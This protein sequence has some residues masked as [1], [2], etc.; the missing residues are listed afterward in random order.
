MTSR[1]RASP[2]LAASSSIQQ[3]IGQS[4]Q[5]IIT[6]LEEGRA[7]T[8]LSRTDFFTRALLVWDATLR[9]ADLDEFLNVACVGVEKALREIALAFDELFAQ[10]LHNYYDIL[11]ATFMLAHLAWKDVGDEYTPWDLV[12]LVVRLTLAEFQ[13]PPGDPPITIYDPCCGSGAFLLGCLEYIDSLYPEVLDRGQVKLYGQELTHV[14]WLMCRI[15]LHLH[16]LARGLRRGGPS[17]ERSA[18]QE[19]AHA[20]GFSAVH[21]Q[22]ESLWTP[23]DITIDEGLRQQ[24]LAVV[25]P[26]PRS[27][28]K[29]QTSQQQSAHA[30]SLF[31]EVQKLFPADPF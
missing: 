4:A 16:E 11:G 7:K 27:R 31:A 14:G 19:P 28:N 22:Q 17:Q 21:V 8:G 29:R 10:A 20:L 2:R 26:M 30:D 18:E 13:P 24:L 6:L 5:R 25:R 3:A 23:A 12:Q 9:Q 15:N 1:K